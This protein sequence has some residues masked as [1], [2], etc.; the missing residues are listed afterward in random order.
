MLDFNKQIVIS[1]KTILITLGILLAV[2][3]S[4]ELR[5]VFELVF[6]ALLLAISMESAV[7]SIMCMTLMNKPVSRGFAV[8]LSYFTLLLVVVLFFLTAAP[9]VVRESQKLVNTFSFFLSN[10]EVNGETLFESLSFLDVLGQT[11]QPGNITSLLTS[12]I[13]VVSRLVTL[14][15][16]SVYVSLDWP[17]LKDRFVRLFPSEKTKELKELLYSVEIHVG[18]WIKGQLT[19]MFAVGLLGFLG[20]T[21][22]GVNYALALGF[23]SGMLEIVPILGPFFSTVIAT[24]V[25]FSQSPTKGIIAFLIFLTIQ[26]VESNFITPKVMQKFSGFSPLIILIALMIGHEFFGL[27]GAILAIPVTMIIGIFY[28]RYIHLNK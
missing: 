19:I 25:G 10:L 27:S 9:M 5:S 24:G 12:S 8:L 16:V 1:I 15:V 14:V 2:Y 23:I 17:N 22:A 26:Q 7:K 6:I 20:L 11:L 4:Y 21:I 13:S 18:T 3:I 28:R